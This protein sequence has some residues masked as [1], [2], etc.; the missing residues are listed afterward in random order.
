MQTSFHFNQKRTK[1]LTSIDSFIIGGNNGIIVEPQVVTDTI[2][3]EAWDIQTCD[4]CDPKNMFPGNED[5]KD[6][7]WF[8]VNNMYGNGTSQNK[9]WKDIDN[10]DELKEAWDTQNADWNT[11]QR[12]GFTGDYTDYK[13]GNDFEYFV[14]ITKYFDPNK[15]KIIP[16]DETARYMWAYENQ[17]FRRAI[18]GLQVLDC[19]KKKMGCEW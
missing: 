8:E 4:E 17:K 15:S 1:L 18:A 2:P 7:W 9:A 12:L 13:P 6:D 3:I 10:C 19:L 16:G 5:S 11:A 14:C